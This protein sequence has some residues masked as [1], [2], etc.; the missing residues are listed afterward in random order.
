M[1]GLNDVLNEFGVKMYELMEKSNLKAFWA[2]SVFVYEYYKNIEFDGYKFYELYLLFEIIGKRIEESYLELLDLSLVENDEY[3]TFCEDARGLSWNDVLDLVDDGN[4]NINDIDIRYLEMENC[5]TIKD[6]AVEKVL[7]YF[8]QYGKNNNL[9]YFTKEN[10][11]EIRRKRFC[12]LFYISKNQLAFS[13]S[14][15]IYSKKTKCFDDNV[16]GPLHIDGGI[17]STF[18]KKVLENSIL[19]VYESLQ[20]QYDGLY[21]KIKDLP[22][23]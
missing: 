13:Y 2:F 18:E 15:F 21:E 23:R 4:Y 3:M 9:T 8:I 20:K 12:E 7:D 6:E 19:D 17:R 5:M 22:I 1:V 14:D 16:I 10:L 11:L